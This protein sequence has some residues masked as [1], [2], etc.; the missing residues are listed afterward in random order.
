MEGEERPHFPRSVLEGCGDRK[1]PWETDA[2]V[3]ARIYKSCPAIIGV[4]RT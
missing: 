1:R 2:A 3:E 4:G